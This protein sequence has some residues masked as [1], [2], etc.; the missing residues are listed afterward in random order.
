MISLKWRQGLPALRALHLHSHPAHQTPAMVHM[1][2]WGLHQL[3]V[4]LQFD[5]VRDLSWDCTVRHQAYCALVHFG[6]EVF[7]IRLILKLIIKNRL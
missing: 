3:E 2:A 1:V 7:I 5:F 6:R 4:R